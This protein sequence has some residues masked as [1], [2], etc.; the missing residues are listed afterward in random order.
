MANNGGS[1][2]KKILLKGPVLTRSGYGEQSRFALRSLRSRED[3]FDIYIQPITW[4]NTGWLIEETEE[5]KWIDNTIEKT[6]SFIQQGGKFDM[7]LQVTIPNEF[8]Q[9]AQINIGYTAG[10]ETTKV[11]HQWI[12][13]INEMD[14]I[15][16]VSSHSKNVIENTEYPAQDTHTGQQFILK[17]KTPVEFVNYPVKTY[18][19][20]PELELNLTTSFNFLA[21]AQFGP[22]KNL[23][24]TIKWFIEEFRHEDVGLVVKSNITKNCLMDRNTLKDQ[25]ANFLRQQ[26]ERQCKVY[27]LH[28]DLDDAEMHSLYHNHQINAFVSFAH[29]E[30]FGL[31]IFEAAYSGLPVVATGWS[32]QLDFLVDTE[33]HDQFYNV[34]FDLQ[35]VQPEVVWDGVLVK[36]SMWSF[37]RENSAK[38]QMR[39][40]YENM[41]DPDLSGVEMINLER[42]T[43]NL[44]ERFSEQAMYEQFVGEIIGKS[45][46]KPEPVTGISFCI[47]TNGAKPEKTELEIKSI[48]K[49][50]ESVD[51]PYEIIVA[52]NT[53]PFTEMGITAVHTPEDA[54][55]GLLAKLRNNA[56][57]VASQDVLVFVDD[58][59]IFPETWASKF[60]EYSNLEGWQVTANKIF[61]PDGGRFWDRA[62]MN[63]HKLVSYDHPS[64]DNNLYQTGGF[65]IMRKEIYDSYKWDSSIPINA[66]KNGS[67]NEDIEMSL[68]MHNNGVILSFDKENTVWH[69]DNSYVEINQLT[70]KKELAKKNGFTFFPPTS[71]NFKKVLENVNNEQ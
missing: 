25:L 45:R 35:P 3:L 65:W 55:N 4:G 60:L 11:S 7:S 62:T 2:R 32:G 16:T 44:Q 21:V 30:G 58:D 59:F 8:Q 43:K 57:E 31:P 26:G 69:N 54:D 52:G 53:T 29:G 46:L 6:I 28:G 12:Q 9:L 37:S 61:L 48:H 27:L 22:R 38:E 13:K 14:K 67:L 10:I 49:T 41:T 63:P 47:S 34:A 20:L 23:L 39:A 36:D 51:I 66:E 70:L 19:S 68:R 17:T 1:V 33:G 64:Y 42:I 15:I 50:M 24:N 5:R 40:C 56:A 71:R 18:D